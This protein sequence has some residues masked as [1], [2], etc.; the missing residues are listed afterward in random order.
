MLY[1]F[2]VAGCILAMVGC[3]ES[4]STVPVTGKVTLDG[5]PIPAATITFKPVEG[6][7]GMPAVGTTDDNGVYKLRDMRSDKAGS[8]AVPGEYKVGVLWYKPSSTASAD[9]TGETAGVEEQAEDSRDARQGTT[10]P[11]ALL[12]VP[13]QNAN[14]SGLS[15]TVEAGDK[16][17][18][19]FELDS[20]FKG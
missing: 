13:Y 7:T 4:L 10:G 9:A 20:N 19:N 8:G 16:N 12:P 18:F 17:E 5:D 2:L 15:A 6:G 11:E 3:G 14:T 1:R